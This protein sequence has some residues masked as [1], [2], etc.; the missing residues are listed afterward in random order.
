VVGLWRNNVFG[1][2]VGLWSGF[3]AEFSLGDPDLG[4]F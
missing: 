3:A 1:D 4:G 2:M